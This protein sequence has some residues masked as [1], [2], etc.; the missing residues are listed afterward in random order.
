LRGVPAEGGVRETIDSSQGEDFPPQNVGGV[1]GH[2]L[3]QTCRLA[4]P[5][6]FALVTTLDLGPIAA[7][8]CLEQKA[9]NSSRLS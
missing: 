5:T 2:R 7:N 6:G 4:L 8:M 9:M 3:T 1:L